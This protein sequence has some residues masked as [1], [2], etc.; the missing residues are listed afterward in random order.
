[1]PLKYLPSQPPRTSRVASLIK[2]AVELLTWQRLRLHWQRA[3]IPG[4]RVG[5][6]KKRLG[7]EDCVLAG[8]EV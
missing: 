4:Q 2:A 6:R 7:Y 5:R 3:V 1:M 8:G